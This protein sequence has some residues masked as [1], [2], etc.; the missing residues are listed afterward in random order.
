MSALNGNGAEA[1]ET[2][3]YRTPALS[4]DAPMDYERTIINRLTS[5][6]YGDTSAAAFTSQM[7]ATA[8]ELAAFVIK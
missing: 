5:V 6:L 1:A 2:Y 8:E 4:A 3:S 7:K